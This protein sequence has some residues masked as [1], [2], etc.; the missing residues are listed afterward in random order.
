MLLGVAS[1]SRA[2]RNSFSIGLTSSNGSGSPT[3]ERAP[4]IQSRK[5][6]SI[7]KTGMR[8]QILRNRSVIRSPV[9][10]ELRKEEEPAVSLSLA[11]DVRKRPRQRR[12]N[13]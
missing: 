12:A 10:L 8:F 3:I 4:L 11:K 5:Q 7:D 1:F 6:H 9:E 13:N 2:N